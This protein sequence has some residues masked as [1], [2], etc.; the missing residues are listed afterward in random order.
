MSYIYDEDS[1]NTV[2]AEER[3]YQSWFRSEHNR[4]MR[5]IPGVRKTNA[6]KKLHG[7]NMA[8]DGLTEEE[9]TRPY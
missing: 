7:M 9:L 8:L 4:I 2:A 5:M 6:F 3:A 1:A